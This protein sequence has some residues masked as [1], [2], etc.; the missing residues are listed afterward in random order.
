MCRQ[1]FTGIFVI[2]VFNQRCIV[3]GNVSLVH[4]RGIQSRLQ[5]LQIAQD[6]VFAKTDIVLE[7]LFCFLQKQR[8]GGLSELF[9]VQAMTAWDQR[10]QKPKE[11]ARNVGEILMVQAAIGTLSEIIDVVPFTG[12]ECLNEKLISSAHYVSPSV[13]SSRP[14]A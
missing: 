10:F 4:I 2:S 13:S 11:R 12:I 9:K 8:L 5:S 14:S 3:A 6:E 7:L 1:D